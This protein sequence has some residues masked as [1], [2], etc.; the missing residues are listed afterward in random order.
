MY[1]DFVG[2]VGGRALQFGK[3]WGTQG[4]GAGDGKV[5]T[6]TT[7]DIGSMNARGI[8]FSESVD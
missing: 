6:P 7:E 8:T 2:E 5:R 4:F 3:A 1:T